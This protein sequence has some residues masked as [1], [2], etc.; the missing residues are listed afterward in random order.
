M[1]S[2]SK[3]SSWGWIE[4]WC[5]AA[6]AIAGSMGVAVYLYKCGN[7]DTILEE[8]CEE[9]QC[10]LFEHNL[11]EDFQRIE[12]AA[13]QG[14]VDAQNLIEVAALNKAELTEAISRFNK[15]HQLIQTR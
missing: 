1:S 7:E 4:W 9:F 13:A 12:Y 11:M 10:P 5:T 2:N 14:N 3:W 6:V 15:L 8:N